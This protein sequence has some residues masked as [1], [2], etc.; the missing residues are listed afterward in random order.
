MEY[1]VKHLNEI[2]VIGYL[3]KY[4]TMQDAQQNLPKAWEA[5]FEKG[6]DRTLNALSNHQ[7]EGYLGVIVPTEAE[8]NYLIAVSSDNQSGAGLHPYALPEGDY[9]VA[10]AKGRVPE[11]IQQVC[12]KVF[13]PHF[14]ASEGYQMAEGPAFEFYPYGDVYAPDYESEVY[15]PVVKQEDNNA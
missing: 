11:S 9:L 10:K 5:L 1:E 7:L 6:D 8:M 15:V 14:L 12:E 4:A 3:S 13:N 2:K